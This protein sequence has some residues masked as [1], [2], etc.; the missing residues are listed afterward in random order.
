MSS[1]SASCGSG[2]SGSGLPCPAELGVGAVR[3]APVGSSDSSVPGLPVIKDDGELT[4][5]DQWGPD[6]C[7]GIS[8]P[9]NYD[10]LACGRPVPSGSLKKA[11]P[12]IYAAGSA[13]TV[14]EV[15]LV[16]TGEIPNPQLTATASVSGSATASLSLDTT[17]MSESKV[18]SVYLLTGKLLSFTG[19]MPN[20][21][22]KDTLA[23]TWTVTGQNS[24]TGP[25]AVTSSHVVYVTA[26]RYASPV[27][28]AASEQ[29]PYVTVL[30][31]GTVAAAGE[32]GEGKVYDAIWQKFTSLTIKHAILNPATGAVSNGPAIKYYG[33]GF[34]TLSTGFTRDRVGCTTLSD[35]L[36]SD[37]GHC[38]S[39]AAFFAVVMAFQGIQAREVGLGDAPGF[40]PGPDPGGCSPQ[41]CAYMLVGKG[42]WHFQN[43]TGT[44]N[45]PFR[46]KLTVTRSGGIQITGTEITYSS[47]S[48]IGQGPVSTPPMWFTDGNHV[49]DQVTLPGAQGW[50]DPSY[51]LPRSATPFLTITD[52]EPEALA[53]FA[54]VYKDSGGTLTALPATYKKADIEKACTGKGVICYFQATNMGTSPRRG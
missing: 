50:V 3:F 7:D 19:T 38:G 33:N 10:Y 9:R 15:V 27:D 46:D 25:P 21:P 16:A 24:G 20:V 37:S 4:L 51:G 13:L 8:V 45:Y 12:V 40:L 1:G 34:T 36:H 32:L 54:V 6:S 52:Y 22:G 18:G 47:T 48:N 42:L 41:V 14:D 49:I 30:S 29:R 39:W 11:W 5:D 53:G 28:V 44:G 26:G 35:M 31:T 43:A 23:I 17:A 2:S